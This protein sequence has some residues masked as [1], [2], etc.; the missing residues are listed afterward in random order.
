MSATADPAPL[1][2]LAKNFEE[3]MVARRRAQQF[4]QALL[5]LGY[6]ARWALAALLLC[7]ILVALHLSQV[8]PLRGVFWWVIGLAWLALLMGLGL[9]GAHFYLQ[10]KLT[11]AEILSQKK[12]D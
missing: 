1:L 8:L 10:D 2:K 3:S 6:F 9:L 11:D 5:K 7:D 12:D 4:F